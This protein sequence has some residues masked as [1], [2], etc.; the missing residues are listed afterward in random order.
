MEQSDSFENDQSRLLWSAVALLDLQHVLGKKNLFHFRDNLIRY[1]S[2]SSFPGRNIPSQK[3]ETNTH[4]H[5]YVKH[6]AFH[7]FRATQYIGLCRLCVYAYTCISVTTSMCQ[8]CALLFCT[9]I[10]CKKLPALHFARDA[11]RQRGCGNGV[12]D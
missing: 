1:H 9:A 2:M 7:S 5:V 12:V 10:F 8:S 3:S 4:T 6:V 11:A